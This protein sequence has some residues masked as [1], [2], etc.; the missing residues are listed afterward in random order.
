MH[1]FA[2]DR[3][4]SQ[5][6]ADEMITKQ[7]TKS[8]FALDNYFYLSNVVY[9]REL[10]NI[11]YKS[12]LYAG[13]ISQI[14]NNGD[15]FLF[16]V[17]SDSVIISRDDQGNIH[18]LINSC[19]HRG[20]RVCEEKSG[21]RK[22]FVCPYHGW[23]YNNDGSLKHARDM[24]V[25]ENFSCDDYPLKTIHTVIKHGFIFINFDENPN[26]FET[27]LN[28][29]E[30]MLGPYQFEK[31]KIAEMR[32]Y[33]IKANWKLAVENYLECYHCASSH[34]A[35]A[36]MH[37]LRELWCN[38]KD[39][40]ESMREKS[41]A[42]TGQSTDFVKTH[43]QIYGDA[44]AFG[45]DVA[46][47]RYGLYDGFLTGSQD[48]QPLST[49]MGTI[50][51]YDGGVGDFQLGPLCFMLN[52]PDHGVLYNFIPRGHHHTDLHIVWFVNGNAVDGEDYDKDALAWLWHH[53]TLEDEYIITR[54]AEGVLSN[55]YAP[56]P[57]HPEFER[58]EANFISWVLQTINIHN[59]K[60]PLSK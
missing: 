59:S 23:V 25:A 7:L 22:T 5:L 8:G 58:V 12:W 10:A 49:L 60:T 6:L 29:L 36:K 18:A 24:H 28:M 42:I 57:L 56:G 54:N 46:H 3:D 16:E 21:H 47:M 31:A 17:A 51:D 32:T 27:A 26:D 2:S 1:V 38:V 14:P 15:Y 30:P 35:F 43:W 50:K 41:P 48:G 20:A 45:C 39:R 11:I 33:K 37:T 44:P 19:R 34:R 40:V 55:G 53:T 4:D 9:R 52:Y 13:H